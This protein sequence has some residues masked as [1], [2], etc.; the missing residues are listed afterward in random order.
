MSLR[1]IASS[2]LVGK[3]CVS[4][5][6]RLS[7]AVLSPATLSPAP[8]ARCRP[9]PGCSA[10]AKASPISSDTK[11]AHR[12]HSTVRRPIRPTSRPPSM[13]ASPDTRVANTS[14][15]MI[16]LISRRKMSVRIEK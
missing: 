5:S 11:E 7:P 15:A 4:T 6:F 16:I 9:A 3:A 1:A 13:P 14:G 2:R 8:A 12:N 10:L